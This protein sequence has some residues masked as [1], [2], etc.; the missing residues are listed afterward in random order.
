MKVG[1]S[2]AHQRA[3]A[4]LE[5]RTFEDLGVGQL[6]VAGLRHVGLDEE[7]EQVAVVQALPADLLLPATQRSCAEDRRLLLRDELHTDPAH[8]VLRVVEAAG[9]LVWLVQESII[10]QP[11]TFRYIKMTGAKGSTYNDVEDGEEVAN[12]HHEGDTGLRIE[13]LFERG[14][15]LVLRNPSV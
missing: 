8:D 12:D 13:Q 1:I 15:E 11:T 3:Q 6:C 7:R 4:R 14:D 10:L 9:L 5:S 2:V